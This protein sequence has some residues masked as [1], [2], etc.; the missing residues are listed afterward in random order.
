ME[1]MKGLKAIANPTRLRVLELLKDPPTLQELKTTHGS[2]RG[3]TAKALLDQLRCSQPTLNEHMQIL[4]DVGLVESR[5][6]GRW[7]F[8]ARDEERIRQFKQTIIDQLLP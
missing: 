7:V 6:S 1:L 4:L 5:R 2:L 3:L 8:Y